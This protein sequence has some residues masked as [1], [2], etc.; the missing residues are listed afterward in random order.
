[1]CYVTTSDMRHSRSPG[2]LPYTT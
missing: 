1:V 2:V